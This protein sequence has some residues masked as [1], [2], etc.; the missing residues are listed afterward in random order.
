MDVGTGL[1]IL[2]SN[3]LLVKLLGPSVDYVGGEAR[4]LLEK[5]N[6]NLG[7][8]FKKS[9][10]K[11]GNRIDNG[12]SVCARVLMHVL[13]DGRFCED[14]LMKEYYAGILASSRSPEGLDDRGVNLLAMIRGLS[15]CQVRFHFLAY[16]LV[17]RHFKGKN[18]NL[19]KS[20]DCTR[21]RIFI[22]M[23][24]YQKAM[25]STTEQADQ[26]IGHIL[27]GL[28]KEGL[29]GQEFKSGH[30]KDLDSSLHEV[31]GEGI[32]FGPSLPGAE[33]FM[34]STGCPGAS[35][36]ELLQLDNVSIPEGFVV[37]D[38]SF[39]LSPI[40]EDGKAHEADTSFSSELPKAIWGKYRG[41]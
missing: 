4:N 13:Q 32:V 39:P 22:P 8:I 41:K 15:A 33:L 7:D 9:I 1:A 21:A 31:A 37:E 3:Q 34:W 14:D 18:L 2:G 28:A 5:C 35:G 12:D 19:G 25:S 23:S 24:V 40:H 30:S 29:I 17:N 38:G 36:R 6:V 10:T 16:L 27:F 26:V 20:D 11:I